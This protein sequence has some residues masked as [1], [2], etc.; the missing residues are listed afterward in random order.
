MPKTIQIR[1]SVFADND[2]IAC[3]NR[4][5]LDASGVLA[6]N[7]MASPGAGK[8]ALILATAR[9]LTGRLRCAV[10][11]GD[12]AGDIDARLA[13]EAGLPAVQINTGGACHLRASMLAEAISVLP[14]EQFDLLFIENV[15]NLVCPAG[16]FLGEHLR[17]VVSSTPEGHDKPL[18]Y[19]AAFRQADAVVVSKGDIAD[20]VS[21]DFDAYE[22]YLRQLHSAVPLF[23]LSARTGEGMAEWVQWLEE[24]ARSNA[25]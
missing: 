25:V 24:K 11:E 13:E 8:T 21:F 17:V 4:R 9:A 14:L 1:Q 18:K 19:P 2:E 16:V 15:G 6:I 10:I 3:G 20:Y 12:I 23:R 5:K 22:T 7:I